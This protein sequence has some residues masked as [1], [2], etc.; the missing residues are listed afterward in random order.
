MNGR[1]F[2]INISPNG[3]VPKRAVYEAQV[4]TLGIVGSRVGNPKIHGGPLAAL[5]LY[6]L[7]VIQALQAE[8]HPIFPGSVGDNLTLSGLDWARVVP[9]VQLEL[10]DELL[11]EVT[12]YTTPCQTIIA[13]FADRNSNRILQK[14]HPG[15]SRVYAK[16]LRAGRIKVGDHV[17]LQ[18]NGKA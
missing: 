5:C 17:T 2:Q 6:S 8:G 1:I 4:E 14:T 13:S 9:G 16:V 7:E 18:L 15:W 12:Q 10:G 3:G 11:I